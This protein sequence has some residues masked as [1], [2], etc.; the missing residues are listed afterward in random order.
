MTKKGTPRKYIDLVKDMYQDVKMNVI[1]CGEITKDFPI[2][3]GLHKGS[4]LGSFPLAGILE[5]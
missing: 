2:T 1:T 3:I 4:A 5:N